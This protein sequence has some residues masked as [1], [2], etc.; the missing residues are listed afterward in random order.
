MS[1]EIRT[2]D[3]VEAH[4]GGP[5]AGDAEGGTL[6]GG[7]LEATEDSEPDVEAHGPVFA[8]GGT[9]EG[10]TMEGGTLK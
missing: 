6:E 2:E 1:D 5:W 9:M 7:T 4:G 8:E 3:E 10:G